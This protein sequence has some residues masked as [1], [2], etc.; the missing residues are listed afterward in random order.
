MHCK[1]F[2]LMEE[3]KT[4]AART[5]HIQAEQRYLFDALRDGEPEI[6][7]KPLAN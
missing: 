2:V 4:E 5:R 6:S 1:Q 3:E 7:S